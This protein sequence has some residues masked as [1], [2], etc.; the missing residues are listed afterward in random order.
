MKA[1]TTEPGTRSGSVGW[2]RAEERGER[3][4]RAGDQ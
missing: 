4:E 2:A 1:M 3:S